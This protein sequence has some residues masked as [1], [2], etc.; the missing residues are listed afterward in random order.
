MNGVRIG[1][2]APG[3]QEAAEQHPRVP[4]SKRAVEAQFRGQRRNLQSV[5]ILILPIKT[6]CTPHKKKE[7]KRKE[8][9]NT[10]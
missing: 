3:R 10:S 1:R 8:K 2:S 6:P 5:P 4:G 7:K 9:K